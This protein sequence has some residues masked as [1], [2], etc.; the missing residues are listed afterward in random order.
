[1]AFNPFS[2]FT[3]G[4]VEDAAAQQRAA[5]QGTQQQIGGIYDT[6]LTGGIDALTAGRTGGLDALTSAILQG[7][8]DISGAVNPAIASLYGGTAGAESALREG[9]TGALS[10]LGA[11]VGGAVGAYSP[12]MTAAMGAGTTAGGYT[13]MLRNA[14]GLGGQQGYQTALSA[15]QGSPGYQYQ[16]DEALKQATRGANVAGMTPIGNTLAELARQ[17]QGLANQNFGQWIS[18]LAQQ[19]GQFLPLQFQGLG[20]AGT[21]IGNAFLTGGTGG[22]NIY[23]G[24]G[25]RLSD[26]LSQQSRGAAD[27]YTGAGKTLA[28]LALAGGTGAAGLW[29]GTGGQMANLY[30]TLGG[31]EA[32]QVGSLGLASAKSYIDE[33]KA[34]AE[35]AQNFWNLLGGGAKLAAGGGW[36]PTGSYT[37]YKV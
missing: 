13:D 29:S 2:V 21:G 36:L 9:Q 7:R 11:G 30:S 3:G 35:G 28:D 23:T 24:T 20:Q 31:Q 19:Q 4:G 18:Q 33:A 12:L 15:F 17:G 25:G 34:Q 27:I 16:L 14:L 22:A 5:L 26:L 37:P 6:A 1:M 8:G 32:G 10:S